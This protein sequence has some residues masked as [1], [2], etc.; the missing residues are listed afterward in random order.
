MNTSSY[1]KIGQF[2]APFL[3]NGN[4][5]YTPPIYSPLMVC[6]NNNSTYCKA[7]L[8]GVNAPNFC[9]H[10]RDP[11]YKSSPQRS[12]I[13]A[14]DHAEFTINNILSSSSNGARP[15]KLKYGSYTPYQHDPTWDESMRDRVLKRFPNAL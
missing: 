6:N 3:H 5:K 12:N 2:G 1:S 8:H 14:M 10:N 7:L 4:L 13:S 15:D 11:C 9:T